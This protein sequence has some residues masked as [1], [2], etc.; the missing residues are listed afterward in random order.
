MTEK[1][2]HTD[3]HT[4]R[5]KSELIAAT[6][7]YSADYFA[8]RERFLAACAQLGLEHHALTVHAPSPRPEPLTIDVAIAGATKPSTAIVLSSGVHGVEGLFG[9]ALQLAFLERLASWQ[10]PA[11]AAVVLIHAVNPFGFAWLRRF[12]ENNVDLNRNFLLGG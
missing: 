11:G 10:P 5:L 7:Y 8:A 3:R 6:N 9:S 12:N 4:T 2:T 1:A